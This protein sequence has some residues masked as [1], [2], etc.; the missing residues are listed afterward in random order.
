MEEK[1]LICE[2]S[3][4]G[5]FTGI[6]DAYA[7]RLPHERIH[8]QIGHEENLRLFAVY[9]E[10]IPDEA[11]AQKVSHTLQKRLGAQACMELYS[12]LA[13]GEADKAEAVYKTVVCGLG[14]KNGCQVMGKLTNRYVHRVFE[15][16]RTVRNETCHWREFLRFQELENG[17]LFSK[18]GAKSN[19]I[20]F[21]MPHF[22]DRL[23]LCNF[24]IYDEKRGIYGVHP[25]SGD[26]FLVTDREVN[27]ESLTRYSETEV[28]YQELFKHFCHKISIK[29]RENPK[30][31]QSMLPLWFQE[32]MVEFGE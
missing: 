14:M 24:I 30:L 11:K 15:L 19:I 16:A 1:Y 32:Y 2:D 7:L 21:L 27:E 6:Y 18:I 28:Q 20:T 26:W 13:S 29:E 17:M 10:I 25:A 8:I 9:L 5:I 4:E 3:L 31:Q 22:A 23:P 12:A